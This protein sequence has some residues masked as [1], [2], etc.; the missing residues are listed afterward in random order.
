[1]SGVYGWAMEEY[2]ARIDEQDTQREV[3]HGREAMTGLGGTTGA[4]ILQLLRDEE[5]A[6]FDDLLV[7]LGWAEH[8]LAAAKHRTPGTMLAHLLWPLRSVG[9]IEYDGR[10]GP[11]V[12][13][14]A[15][16]PLQQALGVSLTEIAKL[17][18]QESF[19]AKPHFGKPRTLSESEAIDI[20]VLMPFADA[21]R[22]VYDDHIKKVANRLSLVTRRADD[23]FTSEAVM[24]DIWAA[25]CHAKCVIADCTGR[26]PNVFYEIGLAH[27]IGKPVVLITQTS[28]DVPF[29]LRSIRFIE[30]KLTPRGMTDFEK[31][32]EKTITNAIA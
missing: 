5:A 27:A 6:S 3:W 16:D 7:A 4:K 1:M 30:Y 19:V 26:N 9:L 21:L 15:W 13:S 20:F 10:A 8:G 31:A 11:I 18:A 25:I 23:F 14:A 24:D 28:A 29:D 22:P 17:D 2:S 12:L 32:L